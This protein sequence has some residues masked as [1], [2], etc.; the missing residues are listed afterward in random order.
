MNNLEN[1]Q[2][3]VESNSDKIDDLLACSSCNQTELDECMDINNT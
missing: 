3:I 1:I 2:T